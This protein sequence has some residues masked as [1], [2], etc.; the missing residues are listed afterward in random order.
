[1]V[2]DAVE[3]CAVGVRV[4]VDVDADVEVEV[5]AEVVDA[6][7]ESAFFSSV[8][9]DEVLLTQTDR[10]QLETDEPTSTQ[11]RTPTGEQPASFGSLGP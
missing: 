7:L 11:T 9:L 6:V 2:L 8:A 10:F 4:V 3:V 5:E 1:M